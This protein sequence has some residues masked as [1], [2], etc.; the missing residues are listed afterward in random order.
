MAEQRNEGFPKNDLETL[1]D[2]STV[3]AA[4][5][6]PIRMVEREL[7]RPDGSTVLVEV[8]V[9]PPFRLEAREELKSPT[10]ADKRK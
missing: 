2:E 8:P 6:K 7:T 1:D 5:L 9:Y 4:D 3:K 10:R